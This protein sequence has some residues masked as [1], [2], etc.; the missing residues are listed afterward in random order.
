MK[1][2]LF[3]AVAKD[4]T[5][6]ETTFLEVVFCF[7][8]RY[9]SLQLRDCS[10][11]IAFLLRSSNQRWKPLPTLTIRS[12]P[13]TRWWGM[14]NRCGEITSFR[15]S[16]T[17]ASVSRAWL[18]EYTCIYTNSARCSVVAF[19]VFMTWMQMCYTQ[20]SIEDCR[21]MHC[22]SVL[23]DFHTASCFCI[24]HPSSNCRV[25]QHKT[26]ADKCHQCGINIAESWNGW[27]VL[28]TTG[29]ALAAES[30]KGP[31]PPSSSDSDLIWWLF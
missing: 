31:P 8:L 25:I 11:E 3:P 13:R 28:A 16:S 12:V 26:H 6:S 2:C 7:T 18:I 22:R 4:I 15:T 20:N 9:I 27:L 19:L 23:L 30:M 21:L 5:T 24:G 14:F 10:G 1:I 29:P 17:P